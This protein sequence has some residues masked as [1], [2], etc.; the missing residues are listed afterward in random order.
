MKS[1]KLKYAVFMSFALTLMPVFVNA[2]V[3]WPSL[4]IVEGI[5]SWYIILFGL[6]IEFLFIKFWAKEGTLRAAIMTIG[7]NTASALIGLILIP[8]SGFVAAIVLG[9]ISSINTFDYLIWTASYILAVLSNVLIE[10]LF[11]KL[12]FRKSFKT[13]FKWLLVSNLLSVIIAI[14]VLGFTMKNLYQ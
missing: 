10:G 5:M 4:F 7:M 6:I 13:N 12:V 3:V 11:L 1:E 14:A 9:I 8:V 2:N